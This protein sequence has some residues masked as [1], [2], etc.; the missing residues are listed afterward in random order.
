MGKF[1]PHKGT[2]KTHV[3]NI[4]ESCEMLQSSVRSPQTRRLF[5]TSG[6]SSKKDCFQYRAF[7]SN[8]QKG[9]VNV[10]VYVHFPVVCRDL[11]F[12]KYSLCLRVWVLLCGVWKFWKSRQILF[13]MGFVLWW[14]FEKFENCQKLVCIWVKRFIINSTHK[15]APRI[16]YWRLEFL[17]GS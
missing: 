5:S 9:N 4:I 17:S 12:L 10:V 7:Y 8:F 11:I 16:L 14:Q 3:P 6:I 15:Y 2:C 13:C 1:T